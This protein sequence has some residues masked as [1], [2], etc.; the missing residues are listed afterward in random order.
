[1]SSLWQQKS[2][3]LLPGCVAPEIK[4]NACGLGNQLSTFSQQKV[5]LFLT[6]RQTTKASTQ[7]FIFTW[8]CLFL[9]QS[10]IR[11]FTL[12]SLFLSHLFFKTLPGAITTVDEYDTKAV[13]TPPASPTPLRDNNGVILR[14]NVTRISAAKSRVS[15]RSSACGRSSEASPDWHLS[16]PLRFVRRHRQ[17]GLLPTPLT[18]IK[19]RR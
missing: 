9:L 18:A 1:M 11:R 6:K 12:H 4:L 7:D 19:M 5:P 15:P 13:K 3:L 8:F 16:M 14:T 17:P 2:Q 10:S